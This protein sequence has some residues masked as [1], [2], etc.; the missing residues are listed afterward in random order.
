MC[1]CKIFYRSGFFS[2]FGV[3]V[4]ALFVRG[5]SSFIFHWCHILWLSA[6]ETTKNETIYI[7]FHF[8]QFNVCKELELG[9]GWMQISKMHLTTILLTFENISLEF[10][11]MFYGSSGNKVTAT[12]WIIASFL[13]FCVLTCA[14][15]AIAT[16]LH[17]YTLIKY[18][19]NAISVL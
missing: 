9:L 4:A 11:F 2:L 17:C 7:F 1:S 6:V 13:W 15:H 14:R 8:F 3:A 16:V 12:D 19:K 5:I 18:D 10:Y